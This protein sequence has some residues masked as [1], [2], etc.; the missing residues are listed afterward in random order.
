MATKQTTGLTGM[1]MASTATREALREARVD[2]TVFAKEP[3]AQF[4]SWF[5]DSCR[6]E[7]Y[8]PDAMNLATAAVCP[9]TKRVKPSS[10]QVLVKDL[11][12]K[13]VLHPVAPLMKGEAKEVSYESA[14]HFTKEWAASMSSLSASDHLGFENGF[15]FCTNYDSRKGAEIAENNWVSLYFLWNE[16]ERAVRIEGTGHATRPSH[17]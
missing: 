5:K 15:I 17:N 2:K 9:D 8:M 16:L 1:M 3:M 4:V 14:P 6:A 13:G 10:R 11:L 12:V 7:A